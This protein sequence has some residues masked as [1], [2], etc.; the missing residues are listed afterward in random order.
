MTSRNSHTNKTQVIMQ[1]QK[2]LC[3]FCMWNTKYIGNNTFFTVQDEMLVYLDILVAILR[4]DKA[5]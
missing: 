3:I 2:V 1:R 4:R 5:A